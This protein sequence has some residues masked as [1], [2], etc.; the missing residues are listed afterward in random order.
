MS[1]KEAVLKKVG[2]DS[3]LVEA[4]TNSV[5]ASSVARHV[6]GM[7]I[8]L[9]GDRHVMGPALEKDASAEFKL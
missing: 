5:E 7:S 8:E 9:R 1:S 2:T 4:L 6:T 3:K